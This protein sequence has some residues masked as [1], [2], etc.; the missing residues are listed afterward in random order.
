ML[1][2]YTQ[3]EFGK[4]IFREFLPQFTTGNCNLPQS[5][6]LTW[7]HS[8]NTDAQLLCIVNYQDEIPVIPLH[9]IRMEFCSDSEFS[10][11]IRISDGKNIPFVQKNGT[12]TFEIEKITAGEFFLCIPDKH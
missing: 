4:R 7:L 10:E 5:A 1:R 3:Q 6:E 2:Q 11:I 12:V 9:Q 8:D